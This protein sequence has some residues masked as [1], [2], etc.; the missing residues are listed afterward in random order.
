MKKET[1][2]AIIISAGIFI[3]WDPFC[4]LMGWLPD[5]KPKTTAQNTTPTEKAATDQKADDPAAKKEAATDQ[6][7]DN[8]AVKEETATIAAAPVKPE[9][10][11]VF[12]KNDVLQFTFSPE[13][14][15]ISAITLLKYQNSARNG[16]V[17]INP[18]L[19]NS[20]HGAL[21]V[22]PEKGSWTCLEILQSEV[23]GDQYTLVRKLQ[24]ERGN[25]FS[26]TQ[27]WQLATGKYQTN[28]TF[29]F[30]NLSDKP[31]E[32]GKLVVF[33]G[34][35]LSWKKISGDNTRI[36]SHR[37]SYLTSDGDYE[38]IDADKKHSKFMLDKE[39]SVDWCGVSNKYYC[40]ILD[41]EK[42][43]TLFQSQEFDE[44]VPR[45]A[46]G[47]QLDGFTLAPNADASYAFSLYSGPK[48]PD[49]LSAFHP[50]ATKV[51]HLAWGPL[52]Y[53]ARFLLWILVK[54]YAL[55]HSYGFS[56]ILLTLIVRL[57]F[58][59]ITAKANTSMKKMQLVQPK[60]KELREKYKDNPQLMNAKMMELYRTEKVNPF[61]GCLPILLQI[62]IFFALYQMLDSA[63]QLRQVSFL[64]CHDLAQADTIF[65]IPLGFC[66]L[67]FN[68][69]A[70]AMTALMLLQQ[71][72]TPAVG[73]PAQRKMMMFMPL[74][75]LIFLYDLPSGL[76]LYWTV[77]NAFSILQ[78]LI[79]NRNHTAV[80]ASAGK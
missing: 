52:N 64:W 46:A 38:D 6:K 74:V 80:T 5:E 37:F 68:P 7:A 51:L 19:S 41:A 79:Q 24:D 40:S 1:L 55:C 9:I 16:N 60:L 78:M 49:N 47:A 30:H 34:E 69:L 56:I 33:G 18:A 28:Y 75:M 48:I 50:S 3:A 53:L 17:V 42:P 29:S 25:V 23:K 66:D 70:I 44:K 63:I 58:Y 20:A 4:K 35:L 2:L 61:G 43:F 71:R 39:Q 31:I 27:V 57:A 65:R 73:D 15:S 14:G 10:P 13:Y 11:P 26:M 45:I 22:F 12:L 21:A 77:S 59:P 72:L 8:S 76:T 32:F 67:P 62:P 54:L 36:S